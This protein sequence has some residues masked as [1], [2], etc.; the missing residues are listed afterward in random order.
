MSSGRGVRGLL[1]GCAL[2]LAG[3]SCNL[4]YAEAEY[5]WIRRANA[6]MPVMVRGNLDSGVFLIF[7][8]GGPGSSAIFQASEGFF[9]ELEQDYALV[10]WDQRASGLAQGNARPESLTLDD[11]ITDTDLLVDVIH[12]RYAPDSVFMMG[13]SWGG[14]LAAAY[15]SDPAH[16]AKLA[17][18][19]EIDG[20]HDMP[21]LHALSMAWL[22]AHAEAELA[23][24][25]DTS[26]WTAARAWIADAPDPATWGLDE[27]L[28][29]R[30]YLLAA[31]PYW[32]DDKGVDA[33]IGALIFASPVGFSLLSNE[34]H[35]LEHFDILAF[36]FSTPESMGQIVLPSL[37]LW[38]A[39]DGVAPPELGVD[40]LEAVA[41]DPA[42]KRLIVYPRSAHSPHFEQPDEV[43]R[44]LRAFIE[45]YR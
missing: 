31:E 38:G 11:F 1:A 16:Q 6:D 35:L 22:D 41:T 3:T 10:F 20:G 13:H 39:D 29:F 37:F 19:I 2:L 4:G 5:F 23:A 33:P 36:D 40:G 28:R 14:T 12:H 18:W 8:H 7:N 34:P 21:R 30:E 25:H 9:R 24:G 32:Y 15:V 42:D 44:D 45:A 17:G 26:L 27:Y 43:V